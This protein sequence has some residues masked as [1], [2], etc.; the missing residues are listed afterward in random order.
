MNLGTDFSS[1]AKIN[2]KWII[3][4]NV[5]SKPVKLL[6]ENIGENLDDLGYG[7]YQRHDS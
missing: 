5:K 6:E 4:L 7:E 2:S 3:N 1:F